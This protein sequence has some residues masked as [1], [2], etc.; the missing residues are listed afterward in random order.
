MRVFRFDSRP[1]PADLRRNFLLLFLDI[2]FWGLLNGTTIAFLSIY[3]ARQGATGMQIGLVGAMPAIVNLVFTLPAGSWLG[4]KKIQKFVSWASIF[5]RLFY[6]LPIIF[7]SILTPESEIWAIMLTVLVMSIPGTVFAVGFQAL[8]AEAVPDEWRAYVSGFRN[9]IFSITITLTTLISGV[10]LESIIYPAGYQL[11]FLFG[12]IGSICSSLAIFLVRP[13]PQPPSTNPLSDTKTNPLLK[14]QHRGLWRILRFDILRSHYGRIVLLLFGFYFAQYLPVP[15][16]P[17]YSVNLM[18]FSDQIIGTQVALFYLVVALVSTQLERFSRR[19][20]AG[21]AVAYGCTIITVYPLLLALQQG[22]W[23]FYLSVMLGGIG[24]GLAGGAIYNYL[25][26]HI[27]ADDRPAHLA[28]YNLFFSAG[29]LF[30]SLLGPKAAELF[31][32]PQAL[33]LSSVLRLAAGLALIKW[34]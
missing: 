20:G 16:F 23:L 17:L 8:F 5:S 32:I 25:L 27:P 24:W 18:G 7:P 21:K 26:E 13:V 15:I 12:F 14:D 33:L 10:L 19:F 11:V 4:K 2:G 31:G 29:I 1:I 6:F 3:L 22:V 30:G 9:T 28:W 34:G